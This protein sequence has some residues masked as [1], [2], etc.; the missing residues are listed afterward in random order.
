[1]SLPAAEEALK[2]LILA[3]V[4]RD[5]NLI[6]SALRD[7]GLTA[8]VCSGLEAVCAAI[9]GE[10]EFAAAVIAEEALDEDKIEQ[11]RRELELQAP[12]SDFPF[13]IL[14]SGGSTTE[15]TVLRFAAI[16]RL[17][18]VTVLE[19]PVRPATLVA[20]ARVAQSSRRR[21]YQVRD[22]LAERAEAERKLLQQARELS[23]ANADL[24]EFA[25]MSSHDLREPIRN[26]K[27]YAQ[28]LLR[29]GAGLDADARNFVTGILD[30]GKKMEELTQ[31]LL[32]YSRLVTED[33]TALEH[34]SMDDV[35][36]FALHSLEPQINK[37]QAKIT[38]DELPTVVGDRIELC[39]LLQNLI[40]NSLKYRRPDREPAIHVGVK[41]DGEF[42]LFS[43]RDNGQGFE[44]AYADR[45]FGMFKRLHGRR[46]PGSGMGLSIC[47]KITERHGGRIWA[48]GRPGEGATFYFTLRAESRE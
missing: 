29:D 24:Q 46:I 17:G 41:H 44:P 30:A 25:Y 6:C 40:S 23:L 16:E 42:W 33:N 18:Q 3:P 5:G 47:R 22:Y 27:L 26:V 43:V 1:M 35:L 48:T 10:I 14:T 9:R 19:R 36:N 21:Q 32:T 11:V 45:I 8:E 39:R 15:K 37:T 38:R 28:L 12:W 2:L 20:A 13:V 4:G 31:D 34:V 7:G